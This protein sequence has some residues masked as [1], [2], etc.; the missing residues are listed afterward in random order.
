MGLFQAIIEAIFYQDD[1]IAG[2][3]VT[4]LTSPL[5]ETETGSMS[6][7][8]TNGFGK[9]V[10]GT[11]ISRVLING[12]IIEA[13]TR[14]TTTLDTLTRGVRFTD[15]PPV[16]AEGSLVFDLSENRSAYDRTRRG[17]VVD[18]AI[19]EDLDI[20]GSNLG[21][22]RCPGVDDDTWREII[23][24]VAYLP[25]QTLD[26]FSQA[27]TALLG[28]GNFNV[29]EDLISSP[30]QV[31]VEIVVAIATTL[32]GRFILNGGEPQPTTGA[33]TVDTTYPITHVL[34]VYDDTPLTRRGFRA[35]LTNY[36]TTNTFGGSTITLDVSPGAAGTPVIVD[37]GAFEAH[38]LADDE[39]IV[40]D[41]D[42]YAYLSDP[43]L[44]ARCLLEQIRAAGVRV[45]FS[46]AL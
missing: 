23:K 17:F 32:K 10:D 13:A 39:T 3:R 42:F 44:A 29:R 27:L 2:Q 24:A 21:L 6:V 35:G 38:Y 20:I 43:F 7:E 28:P 46:I 15:P 40:D 5:L 36:A 11:D 41:G 30:Y 22:T 1:L 4:R 19:G 9:W 34:G 14:T 26:A 45:N 8:S 25:K 18:F 33:N 12:E 31:F 37:Y 16:H